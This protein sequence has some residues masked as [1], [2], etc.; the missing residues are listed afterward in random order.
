ML[1]CALL[2]S[3]PMQRPRTALRRKLKSGGFTFV[4]LVI[5]MAVLVVFAATTFAALTQF[6]RFAA[7]SRLRSHAV[8]L[9]QQQIDQI[10]TAGWNTEKPTLLAT[11]TRK[12]TDIPLHTDELNEKADLKSVFTEVVT[13]VVATRETT[14]AEVTSRQIRATVTVTFTYASRNYTVTLTTLRAADTI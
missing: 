12:E 14:V 2:H 1:A 4:E 3:T 7:A 5:A 8:S 6:N 10:L 13:P 11:G 9:A